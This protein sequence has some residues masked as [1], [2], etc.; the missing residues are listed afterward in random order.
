MSDKTA[1]QVHGTCVAIDGAGVL[2]LGPSG[3]GKSDLAVRL[4]D[5]GAELVA[6]DR[7]DLARRDA[8]LVAS[9][10]ETLAGRIEVRGLGIVRM[11]HRAHAPLVLA[12]R[13]VAPEHVE[14]MPEPASEAFCGVNLPLVRL[15]PFE[16]S[17]L[18]KLHIAVASAAAD[19][20]GHIEG[21]PSIE[22]GTTRSADEQ[23]G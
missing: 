1:E 8:G 21:G 7:V 4:I 16:A 2:L 9:A 17:A 19:S 15:A 5:G 14:R 12:V 6:D 11:G 22:S 20:A 13:L 3:S 23:G 18:A 10:P